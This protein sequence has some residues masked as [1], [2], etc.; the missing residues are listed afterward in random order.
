MTCF[1]GP[2]GTATFGLP[3]HGQ[4]SADTPAW[5]LRMSLKWDTQEQGSKPSDPVRPRH[6]PGHP[7]P[8]LGLRRHSGDTG[9][10]SD[11]KIAKG[12]ER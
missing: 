10:V 12:I 2:P 8:D 7:E 5:Q 11:N 9:D 6:G 3:G 1:Y 4:E